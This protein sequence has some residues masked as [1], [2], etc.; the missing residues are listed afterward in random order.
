MEIMIVAPSMCGKAMMNIEKLDGKNPNVECG[1]EKAEKKK[2]EKTEERQKR[3]ETEIIC[4]G[5]EIDINIDSCQLH[6]DRNLILNKLIQY[7]G[8]L[9]S[10]C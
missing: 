1:D 2:K 10:P 5:I 8:W 4:S 9:L 3:N 7:I 6:R